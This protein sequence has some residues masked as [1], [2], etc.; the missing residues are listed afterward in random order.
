[1]HTEF[2]MV[3]EKGGHF[4][5]CFWTRD[6]RD[7]EFLGS[8]ILVPF[9]GAVVPFARDFRIFGFENLDSKSKMPRSAYDPAFFKN[10]EEWGWNGPRILTGISWRLFA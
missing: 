1:M 3:P 2:H 10:T 8:F 6:K 9:F 5:G 7:I 4:Q